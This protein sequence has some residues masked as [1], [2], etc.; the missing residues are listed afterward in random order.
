MT[1]ILNFLAKL[2]VPSK[3]GEILGKVQEFLKGK[4]TYIAGSVLLLQAIGMYVD[5]FSGLDGIGGVINWIKEI[6]SSD[7]TLKFFEALAIMGLR[8]GI[9]KTEK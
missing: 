2:I 7:A 5:T 9:S 4:K 6:G 1:K 3:V 8:A